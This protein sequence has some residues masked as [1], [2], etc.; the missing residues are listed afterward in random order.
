VYAVLDARR[1]SPGRRWALGLALALG[2][3]A[4]STLGA[5]PTWTRPSDTLTCSPGPA[6]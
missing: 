2:A 3:G 4:A 6:Q 5:W 1:R